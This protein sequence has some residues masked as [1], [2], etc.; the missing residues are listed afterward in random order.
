LAEC[1]ARTVRRAQRDIRRLIIVGPRVEWPGMDGSSHRRLL[2][3]IRA[4]YLEMPGM[5]LTIE[6]VGRLCGVDRATCRI[7]LD[8]LVEATFLHAHQ[9]GTYARFTDVGSGRHAA[10]ASLTS[11]TQVPAR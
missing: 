10:K 1:R 8:A 3:R 5:S 11:G 7:V 9:N 2:E 4:E 6:Q